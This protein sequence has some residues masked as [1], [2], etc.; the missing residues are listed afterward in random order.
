[1]VEA[2][3][4][5]HVHWGYYDRP[6]EADDSIQSLIEAQDALTER[7]VNVVAVDR[8][9]PLLDVGCGF[10]GTAA[11]LNER[12]R[13]INVTGLNIELRQ[14][15]RAR[16]LI[17]ERNGNNLSFVQGNACFLPFKD[18]SFGM[19]T[20]VECIFHFPSRL[21]FLKEA[22]RV[23]MPGGRL[24]IS[25]FVPFAP[26]ALPLALWL[27]A[28]ARAM[29]RFYGSFNYCSPSSVTGYRLLAHH[30]GL[31]LI[32]N[33]DITE[34]TLPTYKALLRILGTI[35]HRGAECATRYAA[36]VS[37]VGWV[38]YRILAFEATQ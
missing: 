33:E 4:T 2:L 7:M 3:G 25:D 14:L 11:F 8:Q 15:Q 18:H 21:R 22:H 26:A 17:E 35:G 23:L 24:V 10:G 37:E 36:W 19:V 30:C 5:R 16:R 27:L 6:S 28:R 34:N 32:H 12:L 1:M 13:G 38:R 29:S 20:A 31:R 9:Q